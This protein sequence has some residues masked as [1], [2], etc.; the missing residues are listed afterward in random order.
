MLTEQLEKEKREG[1]KL[2]TATGTCRFCKQLATLETLEEWT[3]KEIDELITETCDCAFAGDYTHK[4]KKK[5]RAHDK[6]EMLFVKDETVV[7]YE[8]TVELLHKAV[9]PI[10]EGNIQSITVDT[11]KG[12]KGKINITAKGKIKVT[13]MIADTSAYEA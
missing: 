2:I 10:C 11:G 1:K 4:K 3:Q 12:I 13:R 7:V 8:D 9:S 6:I 5:E